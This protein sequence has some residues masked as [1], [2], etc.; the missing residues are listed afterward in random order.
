MAGDIRGHR[1]FSYRDDREYAL[2][3]NRDYRKYGA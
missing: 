3:E 1:K 2:T